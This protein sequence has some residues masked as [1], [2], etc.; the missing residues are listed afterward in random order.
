MAENRRN[1]IKKS[2]MAGGAIVLGNTIETKKAKNTALM[3]HALFWLKN[4]GSSADIAKLQEGLKT[5]AAV[6][7]IKKLHIGTLA[8][9]EKRDVVD[10]SWDVSEI[11]HF[12]NT[13]AQK[14]YQD[15]PIHK[16]FVENY[17]H[18]WA[19]VVVYDA[20]GSWVK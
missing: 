9:T 4:P 13:E 18:L 11:M 1:F 7:H 17:S 10:T 12:A 15:H 19:K 5:L 6:P 3:H 16:A 2:G 20:S 14:M 8:S